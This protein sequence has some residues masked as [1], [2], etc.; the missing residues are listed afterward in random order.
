MLL[1]DLACVIEDF[2]SWT[3]GDIIFDN[4]PDVSQTQ[5]RD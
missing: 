2:I 3:Y 5:S 4:S 1:V